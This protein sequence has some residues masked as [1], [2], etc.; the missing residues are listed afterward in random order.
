MYRLKPVSGWKDE[1]TTY[2]CRYFAACFTIA[3]IQSTIPP[4]VDVSNIYIISKHPQ[5][6][7]YKCI[8][9]FD[10]IKSY[11][12]AILQRKIF[13]IYSIIDTTQTNK[14]NLSSKKENPS[15]KKQK[16][17]NNSLLT[18]VEF[19]RSETFFSQYSKKKQ[20]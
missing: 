7:G 12:D 8:V 19:E 18:N 3:S 5:G 9:K 16:I 4:Y 2:V 11:R 10:K 20:M 6:V 17:K 13:D 1:N 15:S 14:D